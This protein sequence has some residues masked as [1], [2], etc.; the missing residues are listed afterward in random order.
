MEKC[1]TRKV[2]KEYLMKTKIKVKR[3]EG[4]ERKGGCKRDKKEMIITK[5]NDRVEQLRREEGRKGRNVH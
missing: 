2:E 4:Y 3:R 1:G 5:K